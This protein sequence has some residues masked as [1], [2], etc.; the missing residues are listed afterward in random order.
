MFKILTLI[1]RG[2]V[3]Q[4]EEVEADRNALLV[5]D[6]QIRDV[7]AGIKASKRALALAMVE[8]AQAGKRLDDVDARVRDLGVRAVEALQGGRDDL[9]AEAAETIAALEADR[10][11]MTA[12][13][14]AAASEITRLRRAIGDAGFRLA[15]L[16]RGRRIAKAAEA[17]Q[18]L[19]GRSVGGT[20]AIT[21][22]EATLARLR[23]R[24]IEAADVDATLASLEAASPAAVSARLEAEGYGPRS[25]VSTADVIARLK[26]MSVTRD[27][28]SSV[29][30][31][32][33]AISRFAAASNA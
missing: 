11:A 6:Q 10:D 5:L 16:E 20:S 21:E 27:A 13:R 23:A 29:A 15:D 2:I 8:D 24:Q 28:G 4:A 1:L 26:V 22:A 12:G 30:I 17:V 25:R 31:P 3:T 7:A 32:M 9:V 33:A 19:R 18:H 14:K